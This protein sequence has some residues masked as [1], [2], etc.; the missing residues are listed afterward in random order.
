MKKFHRIVTGISWGALLAAFIHLCF[1]WSSMPETTGV[2]FDGSG[3]F[4]VYASKRFIAY[5]FIV[6][7]FFLTLL[8]IG[9]RAVKKVKLGVKTNAKGENILRELIH[10]LPDPNK[11]F[12]SSMA[13]YWTE[14]VIYQHSMSAKSV[15][16][17]MIALLVTFLSVCI[18][19][20]VIKRIF[21]IK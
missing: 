4:D 7:I 2:H 20:P 14:L 10:I 8:C 13:V 19:I 6:G 21:P 1:K 18:S 3:N 9:S 11:L 12:I 5:P 16:V 15:S 17:A